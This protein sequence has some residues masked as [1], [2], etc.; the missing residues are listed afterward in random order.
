MTDAAGHVAHATDLGPLP[1]RKATASAA[2]N[3]V[4]MAAVPDGPVAVRNSRDPHGPAI[5]FSRTAIAAL[6]EGMNAGEFDDLAR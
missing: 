2:G 4:E 1:W 5:L 6:I 3:C